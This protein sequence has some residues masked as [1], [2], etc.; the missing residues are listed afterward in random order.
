MG[1]VDEA[2]CAWFF[3]WRRVPPVLAVALGLL[4]LGACV[5]D[6]VGVAV[7]HQSF[8]PGGPVAAWLIT[9]AV[10]LPTTGVGVLLAARR[11]CVPYDANR[12]TAKRHRARTATGQC[13]QT[14]ADH[15]G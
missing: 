4:A 3:G 14:A 11:P 5:A 13:V 6:L 12:A 2:V 15:W 8:G 1:P 10:A 7:T 9:L